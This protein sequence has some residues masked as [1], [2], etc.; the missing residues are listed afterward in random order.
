MQR[1][2]AGKGGR[3]KLHGVE[4]VGVEEKDDDDDESN[5]GRTLKAGRQADEKTYKPRVYKWRIERKR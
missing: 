4:E 5:D 1:L 3:R 2:L